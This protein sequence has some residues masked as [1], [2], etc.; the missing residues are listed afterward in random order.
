MSGG[1]FNY[2]QHTISAIADSI[3]EHLE[4]YPD[5]YSPDTNQRFQTA[6]NLLRAA[7]TYTNRIDWLLSGDDSEETFHRRL[8]KEIQEITKQQEE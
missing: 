2:Q 3:A 1:Y 5:E 7:A 6:I 8:V 4:E